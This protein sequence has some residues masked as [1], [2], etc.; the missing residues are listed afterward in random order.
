MLSAE[1]SP[2]VLSVKFLA[3]YQS[4][5]YIACVHKKKLPKLCNCNLQGQV[6]FYKWKQAT[7]CVICR[8][9]RH[10]I[11]FDLKTG[12]DISLSPIHINCPI[13]RLKEENKSKISSAT[14]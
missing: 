8:C 10:L 7:F 3:P 1:I 11:L 5:F 6:G 14:I 13:I 12:L 9:R 2:R 4:A